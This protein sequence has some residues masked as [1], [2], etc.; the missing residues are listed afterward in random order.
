MKEEAE[1][2]FFD[3]GDAAILAAGIVAGEAVEGV[4][5]EGFETDA[6]GEEGD[7]E[8]TEVHGSSDLMFL[9]CVVYLTVSKLTARGTKSKKKIKL[10]AFSF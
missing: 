5:N 4:A 3:F 1:S 9:F 2:L 7:D 8:L 10:S 6:S